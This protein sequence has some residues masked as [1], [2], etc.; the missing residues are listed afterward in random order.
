MITRSVSVR[1][2]PQM[3]L[4][5]DNGFCPLFS[6]PPPPSS[7]AG[8]AKKFEVSFSNT[9][10]EKCLNTKSSLKQEVQYAHFH[11]SFT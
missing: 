1:G 5:S 7:L 8:F 10:Y 2:Y 4:V 3:H 11:R 9:Q 6:E